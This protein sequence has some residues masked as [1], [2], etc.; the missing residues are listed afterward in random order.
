MARRRKLRRI[1]S[2]GA[3]CAHLSRAAVAD[4]GKDCLNGGTLRAVFLGGCCAAAWLAPS[5]IK[6]P[7]FASVAAAA[8]HNSTLGMK[9]LFA[10]SAGA[11]PFL[12]QTPAPL[13]PDL[14]QHTKSI[15]DTIIGAGPVMIPL[16]VLSVFSVML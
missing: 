9:N 12:A 15:L 5:T 4:R 3:A 6:G 14:P 11:P 2:G 7:L 1:E 10:L 8:Y 16:F 13:A